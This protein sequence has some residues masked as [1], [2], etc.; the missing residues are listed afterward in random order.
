MPVRF[1]YPVKAD[2]SISNEVKTLADVFTDRVRA[3]IEQYLKDHPDEKFVSVEYDY[4]NGAWK[5]NIKFKKK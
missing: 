5:L 2:E 3:N 1:N 4:N